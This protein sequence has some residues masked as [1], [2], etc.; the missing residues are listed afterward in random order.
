MILTAQVRR[1]S[2][3]SFP[4]SPRGCSAAAANPRKKKS[5]RSNYLLIDEFGKAH[6]RA[7]VMNTSFTCRVEAIVH[8]PTDSIRTFFIS[9][10]DALLS[11]FLVENKCGIS[12][13]ALLNQLPKNSRWSLPL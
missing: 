4:P 5:I 8:T 13:A 2:A 6:R 11:N 9:G 7:R 10:M 3:A 1:K 12:F